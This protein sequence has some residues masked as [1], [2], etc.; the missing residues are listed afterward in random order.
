MSER[1]GIINADPSVTSSKKSVANIGG[2]IFFNEK[3][4]VDKPVNV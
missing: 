1:D 3:M 2:R 4:K